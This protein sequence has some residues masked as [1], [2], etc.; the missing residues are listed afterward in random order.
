MTTQGVVKWFDSK[1][2]YGFIS[3]GNDQEIFVHF[4]S[5][6]EDG[7]KNLEDDQA[8]EFEIR[9]GARGQQAAQVKKL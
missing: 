7:F 3:Y 6:L 4:T 5:I 2:G 1:K 9:E 8:V